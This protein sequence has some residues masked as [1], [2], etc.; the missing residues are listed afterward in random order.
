MKNYPGD[1]LVLETAKEEL[2]DI[3]RKEDMTE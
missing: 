2:R 3:D 1:I